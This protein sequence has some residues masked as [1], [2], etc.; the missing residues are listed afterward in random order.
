MG[1]MRRRQ[2]IRQIAETQLG[3]NFSVLGFRFRV[4]RCACQRSKITCAMASEAVWESERAMWTVPSL[5][6]NS[7]A[8]P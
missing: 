2:S 6:A 7:A 1:A 8:L 5:E 4:L 3:R